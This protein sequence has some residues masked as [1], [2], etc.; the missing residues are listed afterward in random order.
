MRNNISKY[1]NPGISE[2]RAIPFCRTSHAQ[3]HTHNAVILNSQHV[4]RAEMRQVNSLSIDESQAA[5]RSDAK[6]KEIYTRISQSQNR[7]LHA[8]KHKK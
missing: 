7:K 6:Q 4:T 5:R 8:C 2:Q 3:S 1:S